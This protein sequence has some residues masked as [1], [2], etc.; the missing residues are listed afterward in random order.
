M[1]LFVKTQDSIAMVAGTSLA[2]VVLTA[3]YAVIA[4]FTTP[5]FQRQ[6]RYCGMSLAYR[7]YATIAG[8]STPPIGPMLATATRRVGATGDFLPC[9]RRCH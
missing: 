4:G 9:F 7:L 8:R 6:I 3:I 1:F 2:V 5:A